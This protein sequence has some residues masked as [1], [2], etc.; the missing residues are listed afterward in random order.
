MPSAATDWAAFRAQMPVT[1]KWAY[2]DHAAVGPLS[3]PAVGAMREWC[4]D[5]AANGAIA[6][7]HWRKRIEEVRTAAATLMNAETD[8]IAFTHNTAE[9]LSLVAEGFPWKPGDNVVLSVEEFP[10][11]RFP[12][13]NLKDRGVEARLVPTVNERLELPQLAEAVNERTRII[14]VSWVGYATGWRNDPEEL[15]DFAHARD[16]LLCVDGIQGLGAFPLDVKA[17]GIDF[18]AADGR[19]WLLGPEGAGVLYVRGE[20]LERLRPLNVGWN[21]VDGAGNFAETEFRLKSS[22]DRYEGGVHSGA[23]LAG[24]GASLD[25][26]ASVGALRIGERLLD[27]S[28]ELCRRLEAV[29]AEIVSCREERRRSGIVLMNLP[30]IAPAA[31]RRQ[32]RAD[33]VVVNCR[34]GGVRISPHCYTDAGDLDRL[35]IA[36]SRCR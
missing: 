25:L 15:A 28:D 16:A 2:F 27:V 23:N 22:A 7:G 5:V 9:A 29:G 17:T 20:H 19:K 32:C 33:G 36:L 26:L 35:L 24:F 3:G 21:S 34:G 11:N 12:W 30:G 14:A 6:W 4:E 18:L 8:E 1:Q 13:L 10:S 31:I